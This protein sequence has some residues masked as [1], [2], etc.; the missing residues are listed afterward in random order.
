MT[1][2]GIVVGS[3]KTG[4]AEMLDDQSGFIA[5]PGDVS[6]LA[7]ALASALALTAAERTQMKAAAQQRTRECFDHRVIL[8]KLI[9]IYGEAIKLANM[10]GGLG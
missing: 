7:T 4:M 8:P 5:S 2:G 3:D 6:S 9:D 10:Q 1:C